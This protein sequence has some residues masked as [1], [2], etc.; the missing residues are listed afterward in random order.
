[1]SPPPET[2]RSNTNTYARS[3]VYSTSTDL[4]EL[5][6][7]P[8]KRKS[9]KKALDFARQKRRKGKELT[10]AKAATHPMSPLPETSKSKSTSTSTSTLKS[11]RG[12]ADSKEAVKSARKVKRPR[13]ALNAAKAATQPI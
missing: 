8:K 10:E 7:L 6:P 12:T 2:P 1:M 13:K 4:T 9:N 11:K 5:P 3:D